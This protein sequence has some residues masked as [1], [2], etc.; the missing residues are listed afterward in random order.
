MTTKSTKNPH[1][2]TTIIKRKIKTNKQ[3]K[4]PKRKP[5]KLAKTKPWSS[6]SVHAQCHHHFCPPRAAEQLCFLQGSSGALWLFPCQTTSCRVVAAMLVHTS[7]NLHPSTC[8]PPSL[9][10]QLFSPLTIC[11]F[12][13][14]LLFLIAPVYAKSH[15]TQLSLNLRPWGELFCIDFPASFCLFDV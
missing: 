13:S 1:K 6:R 11:I 3:A 7:Q 10:F 9:L 2:T 15:P 14:S 4:P 12:C 8:F 5:E